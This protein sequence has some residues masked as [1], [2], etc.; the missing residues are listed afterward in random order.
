VIDGW[1]YQSP[2]TYAADVPLSAGQHTVVI[3]YF[4]FVG[5]AVARYSEQR[6]PDPPP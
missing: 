4:E 3:E 1:F 2:T 5:G 6:L